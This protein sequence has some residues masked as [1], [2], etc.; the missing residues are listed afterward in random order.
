[1]VP[2]MM[3]A[4]MKSIQKCNADDA[5]PRIHASHADLKQD[6]LR[7][8]RAGQGR[9]GQ[10]RAGQGRAGQGRAGRGSSRQDSMPKQSSCDP[11]ERVGPEI[12]PFNSWNQVVLQ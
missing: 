1:M 12:F 5:R 10:G 8:E 11:L 4:Q 9:A 7:Q 6:T 2:A 3:C